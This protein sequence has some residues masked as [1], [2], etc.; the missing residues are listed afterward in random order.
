MHLPDIAKKAIYDL[1]LRVHFA[2]GP[3]YST[4]QLLQWIITNGHFTSILQEL[5]ILDWLRLLRGESR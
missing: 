2:T 5:A 4:P 1:V 3:L